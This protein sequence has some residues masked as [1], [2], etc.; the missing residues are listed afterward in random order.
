M[1]VREKQSNEQKIT[2]YLVCITVFILN[3]IEPVVVDL[4]A[5]LLTFSPLPCACASLAYEISSS[6]GVPL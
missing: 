3:T 2:N 5:N 4:K 1:Q 6:S